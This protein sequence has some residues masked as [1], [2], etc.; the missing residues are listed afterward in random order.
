MVKDS[1]AFVGAGDS[2]VVVVVVPEKHTDVCAIVELNDIL[3]AP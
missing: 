3:G 1:G 2:N